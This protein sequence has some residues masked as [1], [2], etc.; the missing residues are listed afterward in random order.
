L[1]PETT[2][3]AIRQYSQ[4]FVDLIDLQDNVFRTLQ[5]QEVLHRLAAEG[6]GD[7]RYVASIDRGDYVEDI[8]S[9]AGAG[10]RDPMLL[11]FDY[12]TRDRNFVRLMRTAL[13]RLEQAYER[14]VDIE[15]TVEI[16][17]GT[18]APGYRLHLLQCRPLSQREMD[19]V[20]HIPPDLPAE[21]VLFRSAGLIPDGAVEAVRYI[22]Y[23]DPEGY[24]H[25]P[26]TTLK[27]EIG[28]AIG[29]LNKILAKHTFIMMGPGRWGS[30]N[31]DLGVRV[32]YADIYH[33]RAL[34]EIAV[35]SAHGA[36]AL[37][38]GSH[39][40]QDLVEAG[41]YSVPLNLDDPQNT[42]KK[43][44]FEEAANMLASLSPADAE[45]EPYLKVIDVTQASDGRRLRL[46]MDGDQEEAVGYLVEGDWTAEPDER[47]TVSVF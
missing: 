21:A 3:R 35:P 9:A 17:P 36:P 2:T 4:R 40:Y 46:L 13:M 23:V 1:R 43:S 7:L 15:F 5:A 29:R 38:Y 33:T 45:L 39:F 12:L 44:F 22:L 26:G 25:V 30:T 34:V 6:Y 19:A 10:D 31:V 18:P 47:G 16:I 8:I 11:T 14:P 20:V 42:F 41:I 32:S 28:R 27:L 37:A 24:R